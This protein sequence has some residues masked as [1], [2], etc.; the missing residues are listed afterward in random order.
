MYYISTFGHSGSHYLAKVLNMN[1][2]IVCWHGTKSIPPFRVTEKSLSPHEYIQGLMVSEL[3]SF[4]QKFFGGI[5]AFHGLELKS[6]VEK[7]KGKFFACIRDP[8]RRINSIFES[9]AVLYLTDGLVKSNPIIDIYKIIE[10]NKFYIEENFKSTIENF[11]RKKSKGYFFK[12]KNI[13][14]EKLVIKK[15]TKKENIN[16]EKQL[17]VRDAL[18]DQFINKYLELK[19]NQDNKQKFSDKDLINE[20]K[21]FL[22]ENNHD[23]KDVEKS[24]EIIRKSDKKHIIE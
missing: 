11:K 13:V 4:Y 18:A 14:K 6:L 17:V 15:Q 16:L 22:K 1:S 24:I 2:K 20:Y 21:N 9:S 8:K 10:E 23:Y 5:H 12:I 19:K 3:N 7:N